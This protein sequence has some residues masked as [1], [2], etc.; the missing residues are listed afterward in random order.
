[1]HLQLIG[2]VLQLIAFRSHLTRQLARLAR[3]HESC[4]KAVCDRSPDE[5]PS[6][7][8]ADYFRNSRV[9]EMVSNR[10]Y[11]GMKPFGL[12][13]QRRDVLEHHSLFRIVGDVGYMALKIVGSHWFPFLA[14]FSNS[15]YCT[16]NAPCGPLPYRPRL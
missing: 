10:I 13:Q 12:F 8:S 6:R 15:I 1:M 14:A 5:E 7:F 4:S 9:L 3:R 11:C 2:A 16:S